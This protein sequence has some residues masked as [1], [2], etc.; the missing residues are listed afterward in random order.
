[1]LPFSSKIEENAKIWTFS[2]WIFPTLLTS[3]SSYFTILS[4]ASPEETYF[5]L[6]QG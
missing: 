6:E 1:M 5:L 3:S 4:R 2:P